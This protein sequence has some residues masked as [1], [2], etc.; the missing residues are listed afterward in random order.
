MILVF[1]RF[2]QSF[3]PKPQK[4]AKSSPKPLIITIKAI[5]LHTCG[6]QVYHNGALERGF[7]PKRLKPIAI[8]QNVSPDPKP[9]GLNSAPHRRIYLMTDAVLI[10]GLQGLRVLGCRVQG[11]P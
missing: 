11:V 2:V 7:K 10:G 3:I 5:I 8:P 1:A 6:V 4:Y 9:R